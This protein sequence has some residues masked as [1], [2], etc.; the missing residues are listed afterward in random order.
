M[1]MVRSRWN[2]L[3]QTLC[4][5]HWPLVKSSGATVA[6]CKSLP[7]HRQV[8]QLHRNRSRPNRCWLLLCYLLLAPSQRSF[9]TKR[10]PIWAFEEISSALSMSCA[11]SNQPAGPHWTEHSGALASQVIQAPAAVSVSDSNGECWRHWSN[12]R[13]TRTRLLRPASQSCHLNR[14]RS[15]C[16]RS[17]FRGSWYHV[18]C[19]ASLA[20]K[21]G[22]GCQT[23]FQSAVSGTRLRWTETQKNKSIIRD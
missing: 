3:P 18:T 12:R 2:S 10:L 19:A 7:L 6:L 14:A 22:R 17:V 5:D 23:L 20:R 4:A 8:S 11:A 1:S 15:H 9:I 21:S 16:L 13:R